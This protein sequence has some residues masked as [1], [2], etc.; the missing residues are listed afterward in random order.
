MKKVYVE[1]YINNLVEDLKAV[2]GHIDRNLSTL[3]YSNNEADIKEAKRNLKVHL[4]KKQHL[5]KS[6]KGN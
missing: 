4:L 6:I 1:P 5:E 3:K 2:Q